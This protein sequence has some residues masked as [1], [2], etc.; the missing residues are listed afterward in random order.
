MPPDEIVR[1]MKIGITEL[2][3]EKKI[4][5]IRVDIGALTP[6]TIL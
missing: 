4:K 6:C 2:L 1:E 3:G 5:K